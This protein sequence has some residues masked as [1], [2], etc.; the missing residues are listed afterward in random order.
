MSTRVTNE[1][2]Y[3]IF[4]VISLVLA[5]MVAPVM[6]HAENYKPDVSAREHIESGGRS[7]EYITTRVNA[8]GFTDVYFIGFEHGYY[9]IKARHPDWQ[10]VE[11]QLD[12]KT[13]TLVKDPV[14]GKPRYKTVSRIESDKV[15]QSHKRHLMTQIKEAGYKGATIEY[16]HGMY[17]IIARDAQNRVVEL[18]AKPTGELIRHPK[19]GEPLF[20]YLNQ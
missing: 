10:Y 5:G 1:N 14:T 7:V 17:E 20:E 3:F 11:I 13:G 2:L 12:P 16:D 18:W 8:A 4:I 15:I 9:N 6:V 19:T